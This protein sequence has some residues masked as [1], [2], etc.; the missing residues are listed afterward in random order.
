METLFRS[1]SGIGLKRYGQF[2]KRIAAGGT[3][4]FVAAQHPYGI[5]N[6]AIMDVHHNGFSFACLY[7]LLH[8]EAAM[9]KKIQST[10]TADTFFKKYNAFYRKMY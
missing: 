5:T 6:S 3:K 4:T 2:A 8:F 7:L 9:V 10:K 1:E